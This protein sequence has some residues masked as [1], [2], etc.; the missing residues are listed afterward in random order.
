[1]STVKVTHRIREDNVILRNITN[2]QLNYVALLAM[3]SLNHL[4]V[5]SY[6]TCTF[7]P[8]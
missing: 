5:K 7:I 1:M 2:I 8:L 6:L 3:N 4:N